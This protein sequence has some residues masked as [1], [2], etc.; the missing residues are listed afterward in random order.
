MAFGLSELM[1]VKDGP[2][3]SVLKPNEL[4]EKLRVLNVVGLASVAPGDR[5]IAGAA[6]T[7]L[8]GRVPKD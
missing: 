8:E 5:E 1:V 3:H 7:L 6:D 2:D 4:D